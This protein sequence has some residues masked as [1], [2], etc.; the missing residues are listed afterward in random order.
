[1]RDEDRREISEGFRDVRWIGSKV[2]LYGFITIIILG[3][4]GF[5]ANFLFKPF[6]VAD[7]VTD[8]DRMIYT[9]EWF[10]NQKARVDAVDIQISAK[11][12]EIVA[13]KES[14]SESRKDWDIED[15]RELQRKTVELTGLVQHRATLVTDYNSRAA[16]KTRSFLR[17]NTLPE[18]L[19]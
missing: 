13:F 14:L 5:G 11:A 8:P 18:T 6:Q 17:D 4:L 10:F 1:M 19:K 16:Q 15:K 2:I 12:T 7:K 9:Y 3:V